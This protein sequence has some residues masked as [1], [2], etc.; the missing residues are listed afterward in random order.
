MISVV[1]VIE[2]N[3]RK[4]YNRY[5]PP[6]SPNVVYVRYN[7]WNRVTTLVHCTSPY[8]DLSVGEV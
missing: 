6:P 8:S 3:V 7:K 2:N 5:N 4:Y 1:E